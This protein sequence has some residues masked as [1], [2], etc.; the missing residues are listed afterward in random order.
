VGAGW[1]STLKFIRYKQLVEEMAEKADAICAKTAEDVS[2]SAAVAAPYRYGVLSASILAARMGPSRYRVNVGADYGIY[3]EFGTRRMA[4][5]PY[6][7][8]ATMFWRT[9]FVDAMRAVF[10]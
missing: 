5:N 3:Q 10:E 4:P 1:G 6:L 7:V 9:P 2:S 8:P